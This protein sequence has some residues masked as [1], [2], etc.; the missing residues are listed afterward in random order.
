MV[1]INEKENFGCLTLDPDDIFGNMSDLE[2]EITFLFGISITTLE[3]LG[4]DQNYID[5]LIEENRLECNKAMKMFGVKND[6]SSKK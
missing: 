6:K 5:E 4:F 2:M 1:K 3:K